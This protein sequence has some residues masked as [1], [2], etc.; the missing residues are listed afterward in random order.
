MHIRDERPEDVQTIYEITQAAF[1]PMPYSQGDEQ[2]L[3]NALRADGALAVSLVAERDAEIIGH[4]AFSRVTI[5]NQPGN[6]FV[7]GPVSVKPGLQ[8]L[9]IGSALIRE[10]IERIK[11]LKADGCVLLG[12]PAYYG[13]FGFAHD[14]QLTCNSEA[15]PYFQQ[16]TL[17]GATPKGDVRYHPA[18]YA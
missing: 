7:L 3:I 2:D 10:G 5:D 17:R 8:S 12:Y 9:G 14:P 6:W 15:H 11:A 18:F 1:K 13:R 4:I 16:L